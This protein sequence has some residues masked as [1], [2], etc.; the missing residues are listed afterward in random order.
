[1]P[2]NRSAH[3]ERSRVRAAPAR[4]AASPLGPVLLG[5]LLPAGLAA[6]GRAAWLEVVVSGGSGTASANTSGNTATF[7]LRHDG[8]TKETYSLSCAA[9]GSVNS[10]SVQTEKTLVSGI[11]ASVDVTYSTGPAES[12]S[13]DLT[14]SGPDGSDVGTYSVTVVGTNPPVVT[15]TAGR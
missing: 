1:M 14:A 10:C 11:A 8:T 12:W 5:L 7:T 9:S 13:I 15:P 3:P 6:G 4:P 2:S